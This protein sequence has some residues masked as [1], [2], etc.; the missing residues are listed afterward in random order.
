MTKP[1]RIGEAIRHFHET[2]P[3]SVI[4]VAVSKTHGAEQVR[5]AYQA[6]QRDFGENKVQELFEKALSLQD[7]QDIRWHFIGHLQSNKVKLLLRVPNLFMVHSIDRLKTARLMDKHL[8]S[9]GR[10]LPILIQVNTSNE[11]SKYGCQAHQSLELIEEIA[12]LKHLRIS[13]LMTIGKLGGGEASARLCFSLLRNLQK[14]IIKE[15]KAEV[16]LSHLSMGMTNDYEFAIREG[17]TIV[18]IGQAI[19]GK[20]MLPDSA[21]WPE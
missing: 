4:L 8:A 1:V 15:A 6:G 11:S 16:A 3:E 12:A 7:L 17:S 21:Y 10:S 2:L 13:G 18:R 5:L 20:R 19:F 9:E 14:D